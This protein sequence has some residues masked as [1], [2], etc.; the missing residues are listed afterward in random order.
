[1]L[2]PSKSYGETD[3]ITGMRAFAALAVLFI[4]TGGAGLRELGLVANNFVDLGKAGVYVF[5]VISGFS[6]AQS[7]VSSSGYFDYLNKRLWR[8]APLYYFWI[9]G[10][11]ALSV[12]ATYWQ[13][14]FDT[15]I[16]AYNVLMHLGFVSFL[17]YKIANSILGVEWS[18]SIEV[19]WYLFMP[20]LLV[21]SRNRLVA[22]AMI[23]IS[24]AIHIAAEKTP[25]FLPVPDGDAAIAMH[26]SPI[27]FLFSFCLGVAA[28]RFRGII[29]ASG[30]AANA[31][32]IVAASLILVYCS[33]P[34]AISKV[35]RDDFFLMSWIAF[36][37]IVFGTPESSLFKKLLANRAVIVIGTVSYG[38]YLCHMPIIILIERLSPEL[39]EQKSAFFIVVTLLSCL[40]SLITYQVIEK[41]CGNIGKRF[42]NLPWFSRSRESAAT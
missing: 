14:R 32:V 5:F 30:R 21:V 27:P 1:M 17:D 20:M 37:L 18:I 36:A 23:V 24:A 2:L 9:V 31:V 10:A 40:A 22:V 38:I 28:F 19:F 25:T 7:L 13:G 12:T 29:P 41:P 3:F 11:I 15:E 16:D 8:I 33:Y 26:W 4:H 39:A 35:F 34:S 42:G 6:V